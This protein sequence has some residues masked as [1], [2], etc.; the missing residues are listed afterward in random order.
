MYTNNHY[1]V[2]CGA[3]TVEHHC[4]YLPIQDPFSL[5][6]AMVLIFPSQLQ[7]I[8]SFRGWTMWFGP[9]P[10]S[11]LHFPGH[12]YWFSGWYKH[13]KYQDFAGNGETKTL[14][15]SS[16]KQV[17]QE[18]KQPSCN[19]EGKGALWKLKTGETI[20]SHELWVG[21]VL[22]PDLENRYDY[23]CYPVIFFFKNFSNWKEP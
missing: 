8:P 18:L 3:N 15:F 13:S 17:R 2:H 4:G 10:S 21:M 7:Y 6:L 16:G 1:T 14:L 20:V 23:L 22:E 11:T 19:H 5:L 9:K 12:S